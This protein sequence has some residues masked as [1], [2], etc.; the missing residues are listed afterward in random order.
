LENT[1]YEL[2]RNK[3]F[4]IEYFHAFGCACYTVNVKDQ[5]GELDSKVEKRIFMGYTHISKAYRVYNSPTLVI[6]ETIYVK[7]DDFYLNDRR[8]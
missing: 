3:K 5:I 4:I 6:K 7:F 2:L 1:A 8:Q